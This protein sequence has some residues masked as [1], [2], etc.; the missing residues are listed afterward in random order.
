MTINRSLWT[1]KFRSSEIPPWPCPRC[2][3]G[4]LKL[5]S[6]FK[7]VCLAD[8]VPSNP[9]EW[10][11]LWEIYTYSAMFECAN[12]AC[13]E[14]FASVGEGFVIEEFIEN[15]V[16]NIVYSEAF[17]PKYFFPNLEIFPLPERCPDL[18]LRKSGSLSSCFFATRH[19]QP[20]TFENVLKIS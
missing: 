3:V 1:A 15:D 13:K 20:I 11:P 19:L 14:Q 5:N 10:E 16:L 17:L 2:K 9:A 7:Y 6:D 4:F 18:S 8:L 12:S